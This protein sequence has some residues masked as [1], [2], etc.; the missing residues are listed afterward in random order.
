VVYS[1]TPLSQSLSVSLEP[2]DSPPSLEKGSM[3][4]VLE[5]RQNMG[6]LLETSLL[7]ESS[8]PNH[9]ILME[10]RKESPSL[11]NDRL[12]VNDVKPD[13][14]KKISNVLDSKVNSPSS[15]TSG[16]T[17]LPSSSPSSFSSSVSP[18][19]SARN[20]RAPSPCCDG[21]GFFSPLQVRNCYKFFCF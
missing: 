7:Q 13:S 1:S 10:R 21:S 12:P 18:N 2:S 3:S 15:H 17:R 11:K 16:D 20:V 5:I 9:V 19:N 14:E 4:P 6:S 8:S